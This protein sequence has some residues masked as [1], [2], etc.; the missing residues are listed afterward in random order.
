MPN[1]GMR[2]DF[3]AL[4]IQIASLFDPRIKIFAEVFTK[5]GLSVKEG[6]DMLVELTT[7]L[8][9]ANFLD[10]AEGGETK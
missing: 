9:E 5:H 2:V 6:T 1:D 7:R 10:S 8:Q 3:E 4:F